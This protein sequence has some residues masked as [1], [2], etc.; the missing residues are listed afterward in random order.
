MATH[1]D[2]ILMETLYNPTLVSEVLK[3]EAETKEINTACI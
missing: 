1:L 3:V 2:Q